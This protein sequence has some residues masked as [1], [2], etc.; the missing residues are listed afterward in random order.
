ME[1]MTLLHDSCM[2]AVSPMQHHVWFAHHFNF[3]GN[4]ILDDPGEMTYMALCSIGADAEVSHI[5][6]DSTLGTINADVPTMSEL[7]LMDSPNTFRAALK[8]DETT[9]ENVYLTGVLCLPPFLFADLAAIHRLDIYSL[10][11][12]AVSSTNSWVAA[13]DDETDDAI[14]QRQNEFKKVL[15]WLWAT[16]RGDIL[17]T[18]PIQPAPGQLEQQWKKN[19][20]QLHTQ[21]NPNP[22]LSPQQQNI[23]GSTMGS[24]YDP[25]LSLA[26]TKMAD[27][28]Q[29]KHT[30]EAIAKEQ[31]EPSWSRFTTNAKNIIL[32]AMTSDATTAASD[33][34]PAN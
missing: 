13:F 16:D 25:Q 30:D 6:I 34:T 11:C 12:E 4:A 27:L 31:K 22:L 26:I 2:L 24:P 10:F 28:F 7:L 1:R 20:H 14:S 5:N 18:T 17:P 33:P 8:P 3:I 29:Q 19:L 9:Q 21:Q 23:T 15:Q 32:R